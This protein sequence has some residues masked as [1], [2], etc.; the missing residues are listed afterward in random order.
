MP[1]TAITPFSLVYTG[2]AAT[3]EPA[4]VSI[5]H[6]QLT[7]S[8]GAT[9]LSIGSTS[10]AVI[11]LGPLSDLFRG[12]QIVDPNGYPT[13]QFQQQWQ[14]AIDTIVAAVNATST[15]V[16]DN[17]AIIAL[18]QAN[19]TGLQAA[20]DNISTVSA[21][22][23][24]TTSYTDPPNV[25]TANSDGSIDIIAHKRRFTNG[26]Y[27]DVDAGS[28]SGFAPGDYVAV[29]YKDA[30]REGGAVTYQG[31]LDAVAQAGDTFVVGQVQIPLAGEP[32]AT[33]N[34]PSAPGYTPPESGNPGYVDP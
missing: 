13:Q 14:D 6:A 3:F 2:G 22:I 17:T 21:T 10:L 18:I 19:Q 31:T 15:Q 26:T 7:F 1:S 27:V 5:D 29:F 12:T 28:E 24:I 20:N 32:A 9:S 16:N 33:G 34:S 11:D 4:R 23:N 8:G 30:A 25:L